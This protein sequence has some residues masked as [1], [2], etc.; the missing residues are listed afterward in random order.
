MDAKTV[1]TAESSCRFRWL[2][3][4]SCGQLLPL[5]FTV[6][7]AL[8]LYGK[9]YIVQDEFGAI[10]VLLARLRAAFDVTG[11]SILAIS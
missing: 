8:L 5:P 9:T 2:A 6:L 10:K 7:N 1:A 3:S 11:H 4:V